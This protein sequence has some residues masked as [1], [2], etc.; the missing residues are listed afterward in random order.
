M[1]KKE[2]S[3]IRNVYL[4]IKDDQLKIAFHI[5][6]LCFTVSSVLFSYLNNNFISIFYIL[7]LNIIIYFMLISI[8]FLY[9]KSARAIFLLL[10]S[11]YPLAKSVAF[12]VSIQQVGLSY[13]K[14][15]LISFTGSA[16]VIAWCG[17]EYIRKKNELSGR[18]TLTCNREISTTS[19]SSIA[20]YS[21]KPMI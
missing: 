21:S 13:I 11:A 7:I 2:L 18:D 12:F 17:I 10:V 16:V 20:A 3:F 5:S 19:E 1:V 4:S 9:K 15:S 6:I 14:Y 8:Y